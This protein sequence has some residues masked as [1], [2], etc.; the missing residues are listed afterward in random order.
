MFF[1]C[2]RM[3]FTQSVSLTAALLINERKQ[4]L[5][6]R[7]L[8]A[9]KSLNYQNDTKKIEMKHARF[10]FIRCSLIGIVIGPHGHPIHCTDFPD[11]SRPSCYVV[12]FPNHLPG[13]SDSSRLHL[14]T[15]RPFRHGLR[16][17][18]TILV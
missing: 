16:Y 18:I 10:L 6:D 17:D 3:A 15:A 2:C 4:G 9:G 1:K 12:G 13:K 14:F 7:S 5:L 11:N 8:V